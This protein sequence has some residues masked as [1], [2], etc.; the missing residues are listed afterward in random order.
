[1]LEAG[2]GRGDHAI[3]LGQLAEA[4]VRLAR[5]VVGIRLHTDDWSVE[6]GMRFFRDEAFL[7]ESTARREAERGTFDPTYLVYSAGKL[8]CSSCGATRGTAA[9]QDR[10][11]RAFHDALLAQGAAP[12]WAL[13]RLMLGGRRWP[14][15]RRDPF[16]SEARYAAVRVPVRRLRHRFEVIQKFSDRAHRRMPEVRQRGQK[17][18]SS[19]AIQ[20]KGSGWYITDYAREGSPIGR[21]SRTGTTGRS[22]AR[23]RANRAATRRARRSRNR[24]SESKTRVEERLEAR[25]RRRRVRAAL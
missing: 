4:L 25:R 13:R 12:F 3:K 8:C 23:R 17:L 16:S 18:L 5:F 22:R 19:P 6:Q 7:E 21:Q 20:F 24:K 14:Q 11:L 9:G 1:M 15:R 2:F 10:S